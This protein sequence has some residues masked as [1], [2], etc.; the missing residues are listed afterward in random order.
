MAKHL[1]RHINY[2]LYL[3]KYLCK[4]IEYI[5]NIDDI[6]YP[7]A[8]PVKRYKTFSV[9]FSL[10][11]CQG[12]E[13]NSH[14]CCI[15]MGECSS[16]QGTVSKCLESVNI[17]TIKPFIHELQA[18]LDGNVVQAQSTQYIP[19]LPSSI[20]T[21]YSF[22]YYLHIYSSTAPSTRSVTTTTITLS[23]YCLH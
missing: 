22:L 21:L 15:C 12:T 11:W 19:N 3:C 23:T 16:R 14:R 8:V 17:L 2:S 1:A 4:F 18:Y 13:F 20:S 6:T 10:V 7:T 5:D 9:Y